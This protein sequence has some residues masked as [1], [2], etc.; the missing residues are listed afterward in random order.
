[1]LSNGIKV[2]FEVNKDDVR[3]EVMVGALGRVVIVGVDLKRWK[4]EHKKKSYSVM[5]CVGPLMIRAVSIKKMN[6]FIDNVLKE[7]EDKL[8]SEM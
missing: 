3:A 5:F 4:V 7:N 2:N 1:M 8:H 6:K